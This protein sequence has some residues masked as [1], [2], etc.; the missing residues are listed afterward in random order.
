[1]SLPFV[2]FVTWTAATLSVGPPKLVRLLPSSMAALIPVEAVEFDQISVS[3]FANAF[4]VGEKL[5]A[6][7]TLASEPL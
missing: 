3:K 2:I 7:D 5:D 4:R 1:M 6:C